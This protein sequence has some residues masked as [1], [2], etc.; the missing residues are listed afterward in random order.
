M[1]L[2]AR[3]NSSFMHQEQGIILSVA[4][5][6]SKAHH[7][8]FAYNPTRFGETFLTSYFLKVCTWLKERQN[9]KK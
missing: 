4:E 9:I 2:D 7:A 1:I 3:T 6:R 8:S 5:L